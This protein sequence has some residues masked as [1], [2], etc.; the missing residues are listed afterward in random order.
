MKNIEIKFIH[1]TIFNIFGLGGCFEQRFRKNKD[2]EDKQATN[3]VRL[4][5]G[6]ISYTLAN[7][8]YLYFQ[9]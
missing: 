5:I 4:V 3:N 6:I 7:Y 1:N 9:H 2:H 8:K